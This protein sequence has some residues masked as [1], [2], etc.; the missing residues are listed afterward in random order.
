M[1]IVVNTPASSKK[2]TTVARLASELDLGTSER[3][4]ISEYLGWLIEE[5][6]SFIETYTGFR[7][8]EED[9]TE[10]L[11]STGGHRLVLSRRPIKSIT[12]I[13][14]RGTSIDP[15]YYEIEDA[16]AGFVWRND[17]HWTDTR[18][19]A[20]GIVR[21]IHGPAIQDYEVRYIAG[22]KLPDDANRD[23]PYDIER[24]CLELCKLYYFRQKADP[25][26]R[27]ERV[28]DA[29]VWYQDSGDRSMPPHI[30]ATLDRW[31]SLAA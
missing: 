4:S 29:F 15:S 5:A 25:M 6:S 31:K 10:K 23:L 26:V 3:S 22:Y 16:M 13:K 1:T 28:G 17:S 21:K 11:G 12:H 20:G 24:A 8:P 18:E 30:R 19:L 27:R 14:Y 9:V 2:L 7:F